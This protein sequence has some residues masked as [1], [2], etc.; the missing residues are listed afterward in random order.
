[1]NDIAYQLIKS[2]RRKT[3]SLQVKQGQVRVLAPQGVSDDYIHQ[4]VIAKGEWLRQKIA[5]Q[6]QY[7]APRRNYQSGQLFYYGGAPLRLSVTTGSALQVTVI[8]DQLQLTLTA[9]HTCSTEQ[10]VKSQLHQWYKKQAQQQLL[11]RIKIW[12]Q[13]TGL[14]ADKVTVRYFKTRWGSCDA[15]GHVKLNWLLVMAPSWVQD[16]VVIH[17]LCH[18]KH[19]NHSR[20][21]WQLVNQFYQ[22]IE[23][24]K[25]WLITH[26]QHLYWQ[27]SHT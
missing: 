13:A 27:H 12:Q 11:E 19:L 26:Q 17:E 5:L 1:M 25:Q 24:A 9:N 3:I 22:P 21:F 2:A 15:S 14:V 16:Y 4:L 7:Q 8:G 23:D 18:L 6:G 20:Q 10:Q